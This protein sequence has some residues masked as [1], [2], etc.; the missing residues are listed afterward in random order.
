MRRIATLCDSL[1]HGL[2]RLA[3]K[4][5]T[6]VKFVMG[7]REKLL[8]CLRAPAPCSKQGSHQGAVGSGAATA[9]AAF[10]LLMLSPSSRR[11]RAKSTAEIMVT[12]ASVRKA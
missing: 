4:E 9:A 7:S 1:L 2:L 3:V 5:P 12:T 11:K 6:F 8:A 10:P